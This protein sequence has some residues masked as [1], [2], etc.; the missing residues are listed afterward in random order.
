MKGTNQSFILVSRAF[1]SGVGDRVGESDPPVLEVELGVIP[2][3]KDVA[4]DPPGA[5]GEVEAH[6]SADALSDAELG[7]LK[8]RAEVDLSPPLGL[9]VCVSIVRYRYLEDVVGGGEGVGLAVE[10][11]GHVGHVGD[12]VAEDLVLAGAGQDLDPADGLVDLLD[13]V[14]GAEEEGGAGVDHGDAGLVAASGDVGAVHGEAK[15]VSGYNFYAL[16]FLRLD[17]GGKTAQKSTNM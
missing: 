17:F 15:E 2:A 6:E 1:S 7:D 13:E 12:L 14:G 16:V 10:A 5:H 9:S 3:H 4:E 11:E 8:S